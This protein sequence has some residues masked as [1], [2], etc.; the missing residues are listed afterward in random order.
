MHIAILHN[1]DHDTLENDPGREAREDVVRVATAL[2]EVLNAGDTSAEPV[3][4]RGTSFDFVG[5]LEQHR[6][7][8]V[9]NLCE[10]IAADSRGEMVV[11]C[12]LEMLGLPYT[13]SSALSLGLALHKNKAKELLR[14][15]GVRTPD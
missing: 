11:P 3:A 1:A 9:I 10:S 4:V 13:G 6:P 15:R 14:A 7:D 5:K 8:L 12:L 2:A